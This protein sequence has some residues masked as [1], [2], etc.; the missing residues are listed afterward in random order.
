MPKLWYRQPAVE[1][2]EALPIGNG[3]L[4]AM[5]FGGVAHEHLQLNEDTLWAGGPYQP[6][7]PE[8]LPHLEELRALIFAGRYAEA[9][10][11]ANQNAM[12]RPHLEMSYQPAGDLRLDFA[13]GEPAEDYRRDLDLDSA[14]VVTSYRW[15]GITYRREAFVSAVDHVLVLRLSADRAGAVSADL[16]LDS[17][18]QGATRVTAPGVVRFDGVSRPEHGIPAAI[19]FAIEA[20][21]RTTGGGLVPS[22]G[23][24]SIRDADEAVI[25][26]D[27]STSF[28]R[29]D[30]A[31]GDPE[32]PLRAR[33][34]AV[35]A[36]SWDELLVTHLAEHRRLF[37]SAPELR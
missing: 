7:N 4:G 8:A 16:V 1:W 9:E 17:E 11:L 20:R 29:F 36:K 12:A 23:G 2:T 19:S 14:V 31:S 25:I 18:Q 32:A 35:T 5:V 21:V 33:L 3:R 30:D 13:A 22:A 26:L 6:T 10:S 27:I 15:G 37:G 24:I 34:D 28:R